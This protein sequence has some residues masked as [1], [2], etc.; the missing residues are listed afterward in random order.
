MG[1]GGGRPNPLVSRLAFESV[2]T[3]TSSTCVYTRRERLW[4]WRK[5]VHAELIGWPAATW[6]VAAL[7]KSVEFPSGPTNTPYR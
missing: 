1:P 5:S 6:Q 7:A 3:E 4:Q 2:Q